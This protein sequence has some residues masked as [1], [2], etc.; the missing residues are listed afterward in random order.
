MKKYLQGLMEKADAL[1]LALDASPV[2]HGF[3]DE[4]EALHVAIL[5]A[6]EALGLP[7]EEP[8]IFG[9]R[10]RRI[11]V[12]IAKLLAP[13]RAKGKREMAG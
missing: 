12:Q 13:K 9:E 5:D 7:V 6:R 4:R 3:A 2:H 11:K 10:D 1:R 8:A